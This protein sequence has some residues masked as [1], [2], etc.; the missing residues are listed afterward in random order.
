MDLET[1]RE[2]L[3][4][5]FDL[6]L[7]LADSPSEPVEPY[8]AETTPLTIPLSVELRDNPSVQATIAHAQAST[9]PLGGFAAN[10]QIQTLLG[11]LTAGG[12]NAAPP[13]QQQQ[14]QIWQQALPHPPAFDQDTIAALAN[15]DPDLIRGI[16]ESN[17]AL[18]GLAGQLGQLGVYG[19]QPRVS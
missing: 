7:D 16:V 2:A 15:Y 5:A 19:E 9:T 8:T 14:Q 12:F 1:A 18:Q 17:P 11:Q 6:S 10:E 13:Q 3:T 4:P